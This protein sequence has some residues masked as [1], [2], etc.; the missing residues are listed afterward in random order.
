LLTF[1]KLVQK[2]TAMWTHSSIIVKTSPC[3]LLVLNMEK[4]K[5]DTPHRVNDNRDWCKAIIQEPSYSAQDR[6]Q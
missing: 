5:R 1:I 6:M 3:C 2:Y 4:T